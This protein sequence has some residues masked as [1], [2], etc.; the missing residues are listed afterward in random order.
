MRG[1]RDVGK[2]TVSREFQSPDA[3]EKAAVEATV[4]KCR[5]LAAQIKSELRNKERLVDEASLTEVFAACPQKEKA[6]AGSQV[7]PVKR[8]IIDLPPSLSRAWGI[9]LFEKRSGTLKIQ[10]KFRRRRGSYEELLCR[11]P[12]IDFI[13]QCTTVLEGGL[14]LDLLLEHVE[15]SP[16][17]YMG[18]R[19]T[20]GLQ[21]DNQEICTNTSVGCSSR[22]SSHFYAGPVGGVLGGRQL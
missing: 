20:W 22:S 16:K 12:G 10:Q 8:Q 19:L 4:N 1:L 18:K 21:K 6:T 2:G 7:P 11:Q 14:S 3:T 17:A 13:Y 5:A 9:R 15:S